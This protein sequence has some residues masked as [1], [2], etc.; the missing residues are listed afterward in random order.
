MGH[1]PYW[2][3]PYGKKRKCPQEEHRSHYCYS[4]QHF[5]WDSKNTKSHGMTQFYFIWF[6]QLQI[7]VSWLKKYIINETED[8]GIMRFSNKNIITQKVWKGCETKEKKLLYHSHDFEIFTR[9]PMGKS[10]SLFSEH[11]N[12]PKP[13]ILD[14]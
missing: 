1:S 12:R 14:H 9:L 6:D 2:K 4:S 3:W 5:E 13:H 11:V 7:Y 10:I 8:E